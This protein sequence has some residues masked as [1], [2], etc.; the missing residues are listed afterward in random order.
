M[1]A[2]L[3]Y[4]WSSE[5]SSNSALWSQWLAGLKR[6][7]LGEEGGSRAAAEKEIR[8]VSAEWRFAMSVTEDS[9]HHKPSVSELGLEP[10]VRV[11]PRDLWGLGQV[12]SV[13]EVSWILDWRGRWRVHWMHGI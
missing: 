12:V 5:E 6:C 8:G 11:Y 4:Y 9:G 13:S 10:N 7:Y 2:F 1:A 3:G